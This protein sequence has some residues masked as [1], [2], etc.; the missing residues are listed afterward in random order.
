MILCVSVCTDQA[1]CCEDKIHCCPEGSTCDIKQS[2]CISTT[3][4]EMPMWAKFP[5]RKRAEWETQ[6]GRFHPPAPPPKGIFSWSI[7]VWMLMCI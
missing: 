2:K 3:N 6:N 4:K 1:V 7:F 5:A